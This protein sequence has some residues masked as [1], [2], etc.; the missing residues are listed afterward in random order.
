MERDKIMELAS[1]LFK[2]RIQLFRIQAEGDE[3]SAAIARGA[4]SIAE[5]IVMKLDELYNV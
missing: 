1:E 3:H 4:E 2:L 5:D